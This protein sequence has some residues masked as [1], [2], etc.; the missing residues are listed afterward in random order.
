M[1]IGAI[2]A[3]MSETPEERAR[4]L[5][6]VTESPE[7][8]AKRL[9][10]VD[11]GPITTGH[12]KFSAQ[13]LTGRAT[14][15]VENAENERDAEPGTGTQLLGTA[16]SLARD[17]PGAEAAQAGLAAVVNRKPYREALRDIHDAE[18]SAGAAGTIARIAGGGLAAA[19]IPGGPA[20][21][22][23]RYGVL[24]GLL[25]ANPDA[26]LKERLHDA[27]IEGGVG[28]AAGAIAPRVVN[29]IRA[30]RA[31]SR[32][33]VRLASKNAMR[34]ADETAYGI[35]AREGAANSTVHEAA[36]PQRLLTVRDEAGRLRRNLSGV[37]D[38]ALQKESARLAELNNSEEALHGSVKESAYRSDYEELPRTERLGA[39]GREDLPD[40]D[41]QMDP[42]VL[43]SHNQVIRDYNKSAIVRRARSAAMER[44][45]SEL[46]QRP[47]ASN[48]DFG[49][50]VTSKGTRTISADQQAVRDALETPDI[51][52]FTDLV[53][54]KRQFVGA[55]DATIA[56][57][58]FK[59][60]SQ[61]EGAL[62]TKLRVEYDPNVEGELQSLQ[63]AKDELRGAAAK[64]MPS[65][66]SANAGHAAMAEAR[67]AG[68]LVSKVAGRSMAGRPTPDKFLETEGPEA[69]VAAIKRMKPA[70]AKEATAMALARAKEGMAG[71]ATVNPLKGFGLFREVSQA[72]R[73]SPLLAAL[74]ARTGA[75]AP[76]VGRGLLQSAVTPSPDRY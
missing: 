60:M 30:A 33:V 68:A 38:E 65:W 16:A 53:R 8:R 63:M 24:N 70:Q 11:S 9:G 49:A 56:R 62:L 46:G 17:I 59:R 1:E 3:S 73:V 13:Q 67:K 43:A 35:A 69:V 41:G 22:G 15:Q 10:L 40:A 61:R 36:A 2:Q 14:R 54:G 28:A 71:S 75:A 12:S 4:R 25:Q 39:K 58:T 52:K 57:E 44:I 29:A 66:E 51:K 18:E 50:N 23:A 31:P 47:S 64:L 42:D 48:F 32:E 37:S 45:D 72:N 5:G 26:D 34:A 20:L 6:L 19:A 21:S 76:R 7:G 27:T 74:D 55:D